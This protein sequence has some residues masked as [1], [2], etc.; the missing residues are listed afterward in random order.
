MAAG[1]VVWVVWVSVVFGAARCC[2]ALVSSVRSPGSH[3]GHG[4]HQAGALRDNRVEHNGKRRSAGA[5]NSPG[6]KGQS[7]TIISSCS[8]DS[9]RS[10]LS[11]THRSRVSNVSSASSQARGRSPMSAG[12]AG[13]GGD[14]VRLRPRATL[15]VPFGVLSRDVCAGEEE[16]ERERGDRGEWGEWGE[17][18]RDGPASDESS[19]RSK[20][21]PRALPVLDGGGSSSNRSASVGFA[22]TSI[23]PASPAEASDTGTAPG[24]GE[25]GD[26]GIAGAASVMLDARASTSSRGPLPCCG[27][28]AVPSVLACARMDHRRASVSMPMLKPWPKRRNSKTERRQESTREV[29]PRRQSIVDDYWLG[30]K[31]MALAKTRRPPPCAA[32]R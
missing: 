17:C 12:P 13:G 26:E 8:R 9:P 28:G 25:L 4:D 6:S 1:L 7:H 29:E 23:P 3:T 14:V 16:R 20:R 15:R 32:L 22:S 30:G 5:V 11:Y 21:T 19:G 31:C 18:G 27:A 2:S 10:F 24:P